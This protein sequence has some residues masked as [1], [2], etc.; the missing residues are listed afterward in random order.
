M[1]SVG[2]DWEL[3]F[4]KAYPAIATGYIKD[5]P[6]KHEKGLSF[7][8]MLLAMASVIVLGILALRVTPVYLQHYAVI[9]AL[10][11]LNAMPEKDAS[12]DLSANEMTVRRTL[13]KQFEIDNVDDVNE[14]NITL[15]AGESDKLK[16][17][18][19][20][21]VT[22]PFIGNISLLFTFNDSQEVP[23]GRE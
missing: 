18:I 3:L 15:T 12:G 7:I 8:G 10:H 1:L 4:I 9:R 5:T 23:I 14:N 20:Y 17:T 11:S 21:Q 2:V 6:M 22:R 13:M 19:Q 16:I